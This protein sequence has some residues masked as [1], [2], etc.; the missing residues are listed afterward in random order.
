MVASATF[1]WL[2]PS[3]KTSLDLEIH[4]AKY[5]LAL[6][7]RSCKVPLQRRNGY[8]ERWK[9]GPS[10][11]SAIGGKGWSIHSYQG[12]EAD[13]ESHADNETC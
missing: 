5:I 13:K 12:S 1:Y 11:G 2:K 3:H 10:L 6:E 9:I 8:G 4:F 7:E